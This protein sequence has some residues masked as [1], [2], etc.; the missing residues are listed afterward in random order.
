MQIQRS[1]LEHF[2]GPFAIGTGYQR[3]VHIDEITLL[4]EP[5]DGI[6]NQAPDPEDRLEGVGPGAEVR[7]G[8]KELQTVPLFLQGIV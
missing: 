6:G 1:D 5:V 4:E 8:S 2:T 3:R 7:H